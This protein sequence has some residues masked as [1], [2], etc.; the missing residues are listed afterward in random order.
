MAKKQQIKSKKPMYGMNNSLVSYYLL[1]M[2]TLFELFLTNG[3]YSARKDKY[4]FFVILTTFLTLS[5]VIVITSL[6]LDKTIP[7]E[8]R[9][10]TQVPFFNMSVTDY[11]FVIFFFCACIT[12]I[13]SPYKYDSLTGAAGRDNGLILLTCYL[14]AYLIISRFYYY[15]EYVLIAFMVGGC[16]ISALAIVNFYYMDPLGIIEGLEPW[17]AN[18]FGSTIGNKNYIAI[19]M[20]IFLSVAMIMFV[21]YKERYMKV[22]CGVSTMFAYCG[23]LTAGSNSGFI[24]LFA[25]MLAM[26]AVCI[27]KPE[28]FRNFMLALTIMIASGFILRIMSIITNDKHKG[29]ESIGETLVYSIEVLYL[30]IVLIVITTVLFILKDVDAINN[31]W[32]KNTLMIIVLTLGIGIIGLFACIMYYYTVIDTTTDLGSMTKLLRFNE[33]WGTHR[34]VMWIGAMEEY[35]NYNFFDKLFG[36]GCDTFYHIYEP[37]FDELYRYGKDMSTNCAH[38]EYINYLVTQGLLGLSSYMT[39][40]ISTIIRAFKNS[41]NNILSLVFVMPVIAYCA[42]AVVNI[43]QPITT[44]FLIIFIALSEAL[45]RQSNS[46]NHI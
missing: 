42:Q 30:L 25:L 37:H 21:V 38:N 40:I 2:F 39:I 23:L 33:Y 27:R 3:Y 17:Y 46:A 24:G 16:I 43:Y 34:G 7:K 9:L 36:Q 45:S 15:K 10:T 31:H 1:I 29:F 14:A 19:Y 12:T 8:Q 20:C 41:K 5:V 13:F 26:T 11:A 18:N 22:L 44:P 6:Y 28:L 35:S 32:P 4:W